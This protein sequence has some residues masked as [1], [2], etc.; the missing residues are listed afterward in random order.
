MPLPG[1]RYLTNVCLRGVRTAVLGDDGDVNGDGR[2]LQH[3]DPAI[4][5]ACPER[6]ERDVAVDLLWR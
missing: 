2:R 1:H 4:M 5:R 6:P 3:L